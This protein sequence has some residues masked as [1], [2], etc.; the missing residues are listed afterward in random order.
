MSK[1]TLNIAGMTC[2]NCSNAI[3]KVALKMPGVSEAKVSFAS[4][5]GEFI[6][7]N[8]E[9]KQALIAKIKKL[10]YDVSD[11][12][13][14]YEKKRI[15]HINSLKNRL[16]IAAILSAAIMA[17]EMSSLRQL[18]YAKPLALVLAAIVLGFSGRGFFAQAFEGLKER[19]FGMS[20]LVSLGSLAAFIYSTIAVFMPD[21]MPEN[22]AH[23]YVGGAGMIITFVL[24][25]KYLEERSKAGTAD[26]LK[27]LSDLAPKT[28]VLLNPDGTQK[29][30]KASELKAKDIIIIKPGEAIPSDGVIIQGGAEL[31]ISSLT[32]EALPVYKSINDEVY[33]GSINKN[34]FIHV[35]LTKE[36]KDTLLS[37]IVALLSEASTKQVPIARLADRVSSVFVPSV[38]AISLATLVIWSIAGNAEYGILCAIAV[39]II[40]CP[41]ALGLATPIAV[42]SSISR[43]AKNG[44]LIK[45]PEVIELADEIK[46]AVFDKTGTLTKGE[47]SVASSNI[48]EQDLSLIA[49]AEKMSEHP[50]SRAIVAYANSAK[51]TDLGEVKFNAI[52]GKGI[53]ANT[54][55]GEIIV[56]NKALLSEK[57]IDIQSVT[58]EAILAAINGKFVGYFI[59]K[60]EIKDDAK[61]AIDEIKSL[62]ITPVMMTGDHKKSADEI[63]KKLGIDMV[64]ASMLPTDKLAAVNELKTKGATAFIADGINDAIALKTADIGIAV[65]K[66]S[67]IAKSSGDVVL[68]GTGLCAVVE[69]MSI[70]RASLRIIKQNLF[71]AFAY[72][73]ICIPVA[74]G[75]LYP[76]FNIVLNPAYGALAMC[77]S[78]VSV[79][80]NSL[81]IKRLKVDI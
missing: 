44:I 72:N 1:L 48:N 40:S 6:I 43:L 69:F 2:V 26:F 73:A 31:D 24:F 30:V 23:S 58:D 9:I 59:L 79:V 14:E 74:A 34:G 41:C 20:A 51:R 61:R 50:I 67:E 42:I 52:A 25:G 70:A 53:I 32:G 15:A 55:K 47:I 13:K 5:S 17:I 46:F 4:G 35:R 78:S 37:H 68:M 77:F 36:A 54:Q 80:L 56:G 7:E 8:S 66:A 10:G 33:A 49:A 62:G 16:I 28:A 12:Y 60:D 39:L 18:A 38:I 65:N 27:K 11:D 29:Q 19:S 45:N 64:Y 63:A 71:W 21:I 22:L 76:A 3:E 57:N 75:V 81:R